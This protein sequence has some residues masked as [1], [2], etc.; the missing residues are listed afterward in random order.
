M[1]KGIYT[2]FVGCKFVIA[3]SV[4]GTR[5]GLY[6]SPVASAT[7]SFTTLDT[8][9]VSQTGLY[10]TKGFFADYADGT[11]IITNITVTNCS[12]ALI[13]EA[14]YMRDVLLLTMSGCTF[15]SSVGG[16]AYFGDD[17]AGQSCTGTV[18]ATAI[19]STSSIQPITGA[20]VGGLTFTNM[21]WAWN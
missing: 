6:I 8:C 11:H 13:G 14:F 3:S 21:K 1:W 12:G 2:K 17:N 16:G 19:N 4:A 10:G 5:Y 18:D 20:I 9:V 15:S 7:V